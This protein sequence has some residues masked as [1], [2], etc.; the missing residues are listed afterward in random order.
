VRRE[1]KEEI[2]MSVPKKALTVFSLLSVGLLVLASSILPTFAS[3][4]TTDWQIKSSGSKLPYAVYRGGSVWT[5]TKE[6][7]ISGRTDA[8]QVDTIIEFDPTTVKSIVKDAHLPK[9]RIMMGAAWL[10]PY[11]YVFGGQ[12]LSTILDDVVRY[13]PVADKV[14]VMPYKLPYTRVGLT[15][16]TVGDS[17][18]IMGGRNETNYYSTVL[19][20]YPSNGS[21]VQ[22][23]PTPVEGGGRA[24][25]FT[26]D[27]VYLFGSCIN[28]KGHDV[29]EVD[30][31]ADSSQQIDVG[32]PRNF[33]WSSS[34]WTGTSALIF[35]GNN[36]NTTIDQ[37]LEF[38]PTTSGKGEL[39]SIGK[40]PVPIEN[41]AA[42]Y[43]KASNKAYLLGGR[44]TT[45]GLSTIYVISKKGSTPVE[46]TPERALLVLGL[47]GFTIV[48]VLLQTRFQKPDRDAGNAEAQVPRSMK[49][50]AS[51]K[52]ENKKGK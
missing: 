41:S 13:D 37:L 40:L 21:F 11:A 31:F 49:P 33:Y 43:D 2:P 5:G 9:A 51:L 3:A 14:E 23:N 46:V 32:S 12:N 19:R 36:Y 39:K 6:Y 28:A 17:I 38:T 48:V 18:L 29:L 44:S 35:G 27:K 42:F 52:K 15:A 1:Y 8:Q 10:A 26:G 7:I 4:V 45:K 20:F 24:G 47:M 50:A 30:P 22:L 25:V 16:V 34:V